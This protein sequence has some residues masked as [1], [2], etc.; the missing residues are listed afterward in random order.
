MTETKETPAKK[1]APPPAPQDHEGHKK[2]IEKNAA[3]EKELKDLEAK[4]SKHGFKTLDHHKEEAAIHR[5]YA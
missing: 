2:A 3:K 5:K 1:V 4:I